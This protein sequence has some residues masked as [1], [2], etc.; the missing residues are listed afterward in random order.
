MLPHAL[1]WL[2]TYLFSLCFMCMTKR[3]IFANVCEMRGNQRPK[4]IVLDY[5]GKS[6]G[7]IGTSVSDLEVWQR[8]IFLFIV[9]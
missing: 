5:F 4:V 1:I 6:A 2:C 3:G 9:P 7:K 8:I